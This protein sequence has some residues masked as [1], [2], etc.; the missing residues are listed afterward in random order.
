MAFDFLRISIYDVLF[1]METLISYL[2]YTSTSG[3][4]VIAFNLR[5]KISLNL[6]NY[7]SQPFPIH[8]LAHGG[9]I[10][11][12]CSV[13]ELKIDRIIDMTE[14]VYIVKSYL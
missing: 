7:N 5:N 9:N 13:V 14:L 2:G 12:F 8:I 6:H 10:V 4:M 11:C 3:N 1:K